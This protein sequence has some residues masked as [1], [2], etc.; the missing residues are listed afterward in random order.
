MPDTLPPI[1]PLPDPVAALNVRALFDEGLAEVRRLGRSHWTDHNTHDPGITMLELACHAL[2]DLAY[3]HTVP[4]QDRIAA[5]GAA[6]FHAPADVLPNRAFT[7][8]DWRK[9]L[10]DLP[11]VKNAWFEPVDDVRLVADLRRKQLRRDPPEH[12]DWRSLPLAG[13]YRVRIEFMGGDT[14]PAQ[15]QA[16]LRAARD[17]V[18]ASRNLCEDVIEIAAVRHEYFALCADVDL[19]AEADVVEVAAQIL[20]AVGEVLAPPV[21][22]HGFAALQ[23][24]GPCAAGHARGPAAG[25]RLHR[26][27]RAV[28]GRAAERD[29]VVRRDR[30]RG[31]RARRALAARGSPQCADAQC[32]Q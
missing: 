10:I 26:R 3:R 2:T 29:P 8:L 5:G 11:G 18:E 30:R 19:S 13:L 4:I 14:T 16:V 7:E 15:R 25:A 24:R 23:A 17:L 9:R 6:Q 28:V 1:S 12:P 22:S 21:P 27:R 31:R 20:F 32:R